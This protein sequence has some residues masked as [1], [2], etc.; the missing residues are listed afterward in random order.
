MTIIYST[1]LKSKRNSQE[2][3]SLKIELDNY[4]KLF[5]YEKIIQCFI[6]SPKFLGD[7]YKIGAQYQS[8][9]FFGPVFSISPFH[10]SD[11]H[12]FEGLFTTKQNMRDIQL[13]KTSINIELNGCAV[14]FIMI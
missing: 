10:S 4:V 5:S 11:S 12:Y 9:H 3:T 13:Q 2:Y 1:F 8:D 6:E 14:F 7:N